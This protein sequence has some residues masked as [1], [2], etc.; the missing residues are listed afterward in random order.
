[1]LEFWEPWRAE[2]EGLIERVREVVP[3]QAVLAAAVAASLLAGWWLLRKLVKLAFY[4]AIAGA[5]AWL[6]YFGLPN[7]R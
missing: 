4:A 6:W 1:M 3:S 7:L 5:A 2:I